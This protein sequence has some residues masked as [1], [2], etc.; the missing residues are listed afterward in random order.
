MPKFSYYDKSD[1]NKEIFFCI[2][3]NIH[4]NAQLIDPNAQQGEPSIPG[5]SIIIFLS[6]LYLVF[7]IIFLLLLDLY[8]LNCLGNTL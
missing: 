4:H 5:Q 6:C 3:T 1:A 2:Y 7:K 8:T